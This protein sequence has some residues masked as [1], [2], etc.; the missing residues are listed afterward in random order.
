MPSHL[1]PSE[2]PSVEPQVSSLRIRSALIETG[3][4][5]HTLVLSSYLFISIDSAEPPSKLIAATDPRFHITM[6]TISVVV[7]IMIVTMILTKTSWTLYHRLCLIA[8]DLLLVGCVA[9]ASNGFGTL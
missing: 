4:V 8:M 2:S 1:E 5:I 9:Y 6:A 3:F 7:L